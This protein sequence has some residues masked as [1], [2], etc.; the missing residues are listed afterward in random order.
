MSYVTV[1]VEIEGGRIVSREP[2]KLPEKATGLLTIFPSPGHQAAQP[3]RPRQRV[4][5]PLI[6]GDGERLVNPTAEELDAS[7]WGD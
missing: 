6:Q 5:L 2:E 3:N 4:H 1:E 7:V